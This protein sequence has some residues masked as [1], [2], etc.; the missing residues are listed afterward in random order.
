[1]PNK[2]VDIL[3]IRHELGSTPDEDIGR[4]FETNAWYL[5]GGLSI[6]L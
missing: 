6:R 2:K 1:M 5:S 4:V 3:R